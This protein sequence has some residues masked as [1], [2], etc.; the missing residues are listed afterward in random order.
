LNAS[1]PDSITDPFLSISDSVLTILIGS[2]TTAIVLRNIMYYLLAY[3]D[4]FQ[5]L[6]A[7][8][9]ENFSFK[10][11]APIELAKLPSMKLLNAIMY[12]PSFATVTMCINDVLI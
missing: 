9:D 1:D 4:Y 3:P 8:I 2:D 11:Q 7:E 12:E 6:R 10:Q 5:G